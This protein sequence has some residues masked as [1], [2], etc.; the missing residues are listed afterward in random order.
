MGQRTLNGVGKLSAADLTNGPTQGTVRGASGQAC[1]TDM[2]AADQGNTYGFRHETESPS[3][4]S[5]LTHINKINNR[6]L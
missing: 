5:L 2:L 1:V 6:A 4:R 3:L